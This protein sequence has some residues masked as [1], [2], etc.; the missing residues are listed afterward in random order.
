MPSS[1]GFGLLTGA[2]FSFAQAH[3]LTPE[4]LADWGWRIGFLLALPLGLIGLYI[5]LRLRL[6]ET[7]AFQQLVEDDNVA[8]SPL[9]G[10]GLPVLALLTQRMHHRPSSGRES[11]AAPAFPPPR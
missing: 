6:E 1:T 3:A 4:Q 10:F 11:S 7:A 9:T 8:T 2:A 5:R